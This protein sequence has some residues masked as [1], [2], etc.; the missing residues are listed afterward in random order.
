MIMLGSLHGVRSRSEKRSRNGAEREQKN[1][2]SA[3]VCGLEA[4]FAGCHD[5]VVRVGIH[6]ERNVPNEP[7]SLELAGA[8]D[9]F[10][11]FQTKGA[12]IG[13]NKWCKVASSR[14]DIAPG[15]AR[16]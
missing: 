7:L 16:R 6:P 14:L 3:P 15:G 5:L 1:D 8:V 13:G 2:Q 11:Q 4:A 10:P 9:T 12:Q